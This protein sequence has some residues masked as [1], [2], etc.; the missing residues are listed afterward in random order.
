DILNLGRNTVIGALANYVATPNAD[1]QPMNANYGII[2][3]IEYDRRKKA[4][5]K[6]LMGE[7][8]LAEIRRIKEIL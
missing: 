4:E 3:Q 2:E 1:F 5:K 8:S 7:R 6:A